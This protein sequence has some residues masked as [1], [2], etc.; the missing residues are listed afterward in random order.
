MKISFIRN[1]ISLKTESYTRFKL[2]FA[3]LKPLALYVFD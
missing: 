3:F 2:K 1:F